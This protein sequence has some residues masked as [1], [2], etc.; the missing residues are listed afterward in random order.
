M[1][2]HYLQLNPMEAY[3]SPES[4]GSQV[5]RALRCSQSVTVLPVRGREAFLCEE[6]ADL[7]SPAIATEYAIT[8]KAGDKI[9]VHTPWRFSEAGRRFT[10]EPRTDY[11]GGGNKILLI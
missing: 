9:K 4:W 7:A 1:I 10:R 11:P 6:M 2:A 5:L 3:T 8:S